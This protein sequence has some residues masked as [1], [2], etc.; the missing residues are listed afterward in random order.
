MK[1]IKY[2][3][4]AVW[5]ILLLMG[6]G[7]GSGTSDDTEGY[8]QYYVNTEETRLLQDAFTTQ[9]TEAT[10]LVTAMTDT[11]KKQ[12]KG[13][14]LE[15][16][17]PENVQIL[18]CDLKEEHLTLN[19]SED[20][21]T[22]EDTRKIL[23]Q[24]GLVRSF[25]QFDGVKD[26]TFEVNGQILTDRMGQAVG[27]L[28]ADDFV[29]SEGREI[30]AYQYGSFTLY[31]ADASGK[32]LVA[33]KQKVYYSSSEPKEREVVELL[34]KGPLSEKL[35]ATLSPDVGILNVT[36]SDGVVYVNLNDAFLNGTPEI[37]ERVVVYSLV[38]SL[39]E[40]EG[41][42]KVQISVNGETRYTL[43]DGI[44]LSKFMTKNTELIEE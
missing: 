1:K 24:A 18:S 4:L 43:G 39:L 22:L 19:L 12:E 35:R 42:S 7:I 23:L 9:E 33:E 3:I 13:T 36:L 25:V 28:S 41:T 20:Y 14:Y 10:G 29:E 11:L 26:V 34:L 6:C 44:D 38:N 8:V 15:P 16:L 37:A 21:Q 32:K 40:L 2:G 17:L 5:L 31:F 27:A 30:D